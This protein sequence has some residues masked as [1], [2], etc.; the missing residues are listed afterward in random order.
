MKHLSAKQIKQA[1][2]NRLIS[3]PQACHLARQWNK[4]NTITK[5]IVL[6]RIVYQA[7]AEILLRDYPQQCEECKV[8]LI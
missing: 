3:R 2:A 8:K 1:Y 4:G 6:D 7:A 5:L